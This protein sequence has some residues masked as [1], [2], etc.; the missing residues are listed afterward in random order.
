MAAYVVSDSILQ[1][2]MN[3]LEQHDGNKS[4]AAAALGWDRSTFRHRVESARRRGINTTVEKI[5]TLH[6]WNPEADLTKSIP[7]PLI[8][9]GTSTLYGDDGALKLQWVKTKLDD[10]KVEAALRAAVEELATSMPRAEPIASP[11]HFIDELCSLITLTDCHI[12]M[13]AWKPETGDDWDL[14]IAE[15][16]LTR[17]VDYLID[18]SPPASLC[19]INQ[20]GDFLH[21]D[22]LSPVT[23]LHGHLLDA[24]SRY[25]K[26]VR[27][28]TKIL[29]YAVDKALKH[30]EKVVVLISEGN[31]DMASSVWLRHLFG[32][33]YENEPRATI[34]E[35][36]MPYSVYVH[37]S[38]LLAFHHGHLTKIDKLPLLFAAQFPVE[39]GATIYRFCHTGHQHHEEEKEHSGMTVIM[40]PTMA[41][42]DSYASRGGWIAARRMNSITY[43][44]K[45]GRV[46][47]TTV[48]PEML[49]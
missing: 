32:L 28:A 20:L 38:S 18:A 4:R 45:H 39:W 49:S 19:F 22:S 15:T 7:S 30:Y 8:I 5:E 26:V 17:A 3:C 41:G 27:V 6:G 16:M 31:H 11:T 42:R 9:R 44:T 10:A 43:H 46:A 40:H 23:P 48:V 34:M 33:L 25:S 13:R 12:G 37:G 14:A 21:F 29:R 2:A 36:E 24:D 1:E 35:A 47:T